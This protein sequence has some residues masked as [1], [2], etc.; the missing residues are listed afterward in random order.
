M[1]VPKI[2]SKLP[3]VKVNIT[4][5]NIPGNV[6]LADSRFYEPSEIDILI[7][8]DMFWNLITGQQIKL[9]KGLP[10]LLHSR[11]GWLVT[12]P[13]DIRNMSNSEVKCNLTT[14]LSEQ[15]ERFW[16]VEELFDKNITSS[17]EE[18]FCKRHFLDNM[19][20]T[21]D[22]RFCVKI[23]FHTSPGVLGDSLGIA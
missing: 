17:H 2:T 6:D 21:M 20:R 11:L 10:T 5:W 8:A 15:I 3:N 4:N 13:I 18:D 23:P 12:G 22:G 1:I 19:Y 14:G 9:G 7:G 16:K